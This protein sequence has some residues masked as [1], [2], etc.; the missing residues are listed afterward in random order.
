MSSTSHI[1]LAAAQLIA[2]EIPEIGAVENIWCTPA[3]SALILCAEPESF[4]MKGI[5][6]FGAVEMQGNHRAIA[7]TRFAFV[8]WRGDTKHW[9]AWPFAKE[10]P[11]SGRFEQAFYT[12]SFEKRIVK[13]EGLVLIVGTKH[14]VGDHRVSPVCD[15]GG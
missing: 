12:G 9:L 2:V 15:F 3:W 7:E 14:G 8:I 13:S 1:H 11:T 4:G 6:F 5:D 10:L